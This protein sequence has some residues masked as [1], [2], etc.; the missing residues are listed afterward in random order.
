MQHE[1]HT[2]GID[3]SALGAHRQS[4]EPGRGDR[5]HGSARPEPVLRREAGA[6][7]RQHEHSQAARDRLHRPLR[8]RQVDPAA[9]LQ[10]DE[11]SGRRLPRRRRDPTSTATTST[12]RARTSPSCAAASAWCSRSPTR[13]P[14]PSTRTWS[15]ACASRASTRSAYSTRPSSGH[16]KGA[17]L[18]EEVKDRLHDSALGLSGGQQQRLVIA[19]TIAVRAGSAAA[20]RTLLGAGP[21]LHAQGR[22]ADLRTEV[23]V[24]HRHR[25]P[26]HAA[27]GAGFGLHRV[28]VHGKLIEYGDTDTLFTNP[29]KKQTEDYITGRYG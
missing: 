3:M 25:D 28:H 6:V 17:A 22:R 12:A 15:T 29:A 19:R 27:G 14:R 10:P 20:R 5:G 4:S 7:R 1:A 8:L 21:D 24:H 9:H 26:Q 11:R 13:S 16:S 18:W 2:H 23:Q